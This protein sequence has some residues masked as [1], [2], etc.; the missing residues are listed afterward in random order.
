MYP[1][2]GLFRQ[3]EMLLWMLDG[4]CFVGILLTYL[5]F[6]ESVGDVLVNGRPPERLSNAFL[7][8][9]NSCMAPHRGGMC[10]VNDF[11]P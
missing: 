4:T 7:R 6:S 2:I 10:F 1:V 9:E 8:F 3:L 11:L 5:T